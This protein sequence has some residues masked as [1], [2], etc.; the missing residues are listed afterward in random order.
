MVIEMNL[1][2]REGTSE[3]FLKVYVGM[4]LGWK[5]RVLYLPEKYLT[6]E[7]NP[8]GPWRVLGLVGAAKFLKLIPLEN[9]TLTAVSCFCS[10]SLMNHYS[11]QYFVY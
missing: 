4:F 8:V 11:F 2:V 3:S 7:Q 9:I 1:N 6:R 10:C 5:Q